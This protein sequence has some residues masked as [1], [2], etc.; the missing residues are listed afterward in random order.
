MLLPPPWFTAD[1]QLTVTATAL[2]SLSV[3]PACLGVTTDGLISI[4]AFPAPD[5]VDVTV[6]ASATVVTTLTGPPLAPTPGLRLTC[7]SL[8]EHRVRV[9]VDD[10]TTVSVD[11]V[12]E[13]DDVVD[14]G[15]SAT[16]VAQGNDPAG[17]SAEVG[18]FETG[19]PTG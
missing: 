1:D 9:V 10:G 13:L 8:G 18:R 11:R 19:T 5:R 12:L 16:L 17:T 4:A 2:G 14:A 3:G 7:A 6:G 15:W